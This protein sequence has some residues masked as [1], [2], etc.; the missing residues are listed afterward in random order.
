[1]ASQAAR[2]TWSAPP[3][4]GIPWSIGIL[5][6]Y[7]VLIAIFGKGPTYLLYPP[8]YLG[9]IV[10][11]C[12]VTYCLFRRGWR[13]FL[14][15]DETG[16]T[17][18]IL[19]FMLLGAARSVPGVF[20]YGLEAVRDAAVWYYAIFFFVGMEVARH[21]EWRAKIW[22][23]LVI[24][25]SGALI[26]GLVNV[27]SKQFFHVRPADLGL[28]ILPWRGESV[29]SNDEYGMVEQMA[30]GALIV[31]NPR[32]RQKHYGWALYLLIPLAILGVGMTIAAH[33]R[34]VR[35]GLAMGVLI[36]LMLYLAPGRL[37]MSARR[38][39]AGFLGLCAL[40]VVGL[41]VAPDFVA[42]QTNF[43][44]FTSGGADQ[45]NTQYR[46]T[47]WRHLYA[48]VNSENPVVGLGFGQNLNHYNP[49]ITR[50]A[51]RIGMDF[52]DGNNP[53]ERWP[54]RSP[55]SINMTI[56]SRMGYLGGALWLAILALGLGGL[57]SQ[58]WKGKWRGKKF[59][60][61]GREEMAFWLVM[62]VAT[63]GN[64]SFG[65]LMEGPVLGIWFWFALGYSRRLSRS[66]SMTPVP[67][68]L[69][70]SYL[71]T[72]WRSRTQPFGLLDSAW[73]HQTASTKAEGEGIAQ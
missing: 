61:D 16:I 33:G 26:W 37:L 49:L 35:V 38:F 50:N 18:L 43:S 12:S 29:L 45:A 73:R 46:T 57:F 70:N 34:G 24:G 32:L 14:L 7:L 15:P 31:L 72:S 63:W 8:F 11:V 47:W 52:G 66:A 6:A 22:R 10:L 9:E 42:R 19:C 44:R 13:R 23:V 27:V 40:L 4:K 64:A 28:L 39:G 25:W 54:V 1:M 71:Q 5:I 41:M 62:L 51:Y 36:T 20:E 55:H 21:T 53:N 17:I 30:L 56:F 59:S 58:V 2:P 69:R 67:V 68:T 65:V 48:A 60:M 3:A